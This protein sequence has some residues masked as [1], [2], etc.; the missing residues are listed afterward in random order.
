MKLAQEIFVRSITTSHTTY[1]AFKVDPPDPDDKTIAAAVLAESGMEWE[2]GAKPTWLTTVKEDPD[3]V[4]DIA[5]DAIAAAE[6]F[7]EAWGHKQ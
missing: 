1:S 7:F 6:A 4:V 2:I 5:R 3:S